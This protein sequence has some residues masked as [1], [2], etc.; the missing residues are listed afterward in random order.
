MRRKFIA[1]LR[2]LFAAWPLASRVQ[3]SRFAAHLAFYPTSCHIRL[4]DE[5]CVGDAPIRIFHGTADDAA[6]IDRCREYVARLRNT[7]KDV[8]LSEYAGAKHWF[9]NAD[10]ANRQ[11]ASGERRAANWQEWDRRA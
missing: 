11:T 2:K 1:A 8:A 4:A 9:D 10:L 6:I 3:R 5:D 7:G